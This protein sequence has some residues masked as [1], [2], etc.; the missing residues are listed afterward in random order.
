MTQYRNLIGGRLET[1]DATIQVINPANRNTIAHVPDLSQT[2]LEQAVVAATTAFATW[3][4]TALKHRQTLL[5][6]LSKAILDNK[7]EL[8]TLLT[9]EQGKPLANAQGEIQRCAD[10]L[11]YFSKIPELVGLMERRIDDHA[12]AS[13]VPLGVVA[14]I[15][16]WNF[17]MSLAIWK[18]APAILMGNTVIWKPSPFTPLTSLRLGEIIKD[19]VPAGVINIITGGDKLARALT[20]HP[21][22]NKI[23]FTG[24]TQTGKA[25]MATAAQSIKRITLELGGN[26]PAIVMDDADLEKHIPGI[27]WGAFANNAQFCVA[28]KRL[29]VHEKIKDQFLKRFIEYG[30]NVIVG[31]GLDPAVG[32]GPIQNESQ[33]FKVSAMIN[34]AK[35]RGLEMITLTETVPSAGYFVPVTLVINPADEDETVVTEA[36]GPVLPIL[37]F[38]DVEEVIRRANDSAYGLASSVWAQDTTLAQ[39]IAKRLQSGTTWINTIH[40]IKPQIPFS[41]HKQSGLGLENG[42]EVLSEYANTKSIVVGQ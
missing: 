13:K 23:A 14:A 2:Q 33:F 22:I 37:F 36:F 34:A 4:E 28:I 25:I 40:V 26:D 31:D 20:A 9:T 19:L 38:N 15:V 17:P 21:L 27:F 29:Y 30:R 11:S 1:A 35:E 8:S 7:T 5:S 32:I 10:W 24:S 3:S 41:G 6:R 16:P 42:I 39:G 12:F 18:V